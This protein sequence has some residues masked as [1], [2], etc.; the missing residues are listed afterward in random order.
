MDKKTAHGLAGKPGNGKNSPVIGNNGLQTK[1]GD[2]SR[3]AKLAFDLMKFPPV[4]RNDIPAL[5]KRMDEYVQWCIDNDVKPGN[6]ACYAALG[7]DKGV[8]Y[9]WEVGR[10]GTSEH[11][12]FIKKVK[13]FCATNR[14]L[15]M[16]DNKV[17][18]ITGLFWQKN[19]DGLVDKQE[20]VLTPSHKAEDEYDV[21][22][23]K[24]HFLIEGDVETD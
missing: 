6:L 20:Y 11:S 10:M 19:Y 1:P 5:Y 4:E 16:Q 13:R 17:N 15:L 7:I 23:I 21:D 2:N 8:A 9:E 18:V 3:Y 22:E 14:E 24:K 12:D